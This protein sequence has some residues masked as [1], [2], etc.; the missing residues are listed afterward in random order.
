MFEKKI[1]FSFVSIMPFWALSQS[2]NSG[3]G[4]TVPQSKLEVK[5]N[6]TTSATSAFCVKNASTGSDS[7]MFII[8]NDGNVGIGTNAPTSRL[9]TVASGAKTVNFTGSYLSNTATSS[10]ASITKYGLDLQST[11]TW[12][13]TSALNIGLN[14]NATGGTTNYAALF[15]GG[16]VGVGTSTPSTALNVYGTLQTGPTSGGSSKVLL[17]NNAGY[18]LGMYTQWSSVGFTMGWE[19]GY[20]FYTR[21]ATGNQ[22][23]HITDFSGSVSKT[24]RNSTSSTYIEEYSSKNWILGF[25]GSGSGYVM[26]FEDGQSSHASKGS[27]GILF[28]RPGGASYWTRTYDPCLTIRNGAYMTEAAG[29][30][31]GNKAYWYRNG[32]IGIGTDNTDGAATTP[33]IGAITVNQGTK[34]GWLNSSQSTLATISTSGSSTFVSTNNSNGVPVQG[35]TVGTEVTANGITRTVTNVSISGFSVNSAVD[36]SA[37]YT[38]TY[39]NPYLSFRDG[40]APIMHVDP[41]G[42]VG[43]GTAT[44]TSI[45]HTIA[46]GAKTANYT[47]NYF[48]N[49]ATSS[50]ASI[51]KY[52]ADIQSTGTWNGTSAVNVGLNVNAT[53]GTTNYAALFSGGNVGVGTTMPKSTLHSSGSIGVKTTSKTATYTAA[54]ETVILCDATSASFTINL[55]AS[56]GVTDRVYIIKKTD[57]SGNTITVDGNAS[58]TIDGAA[59]KIISTQYD[60]VTVVCDGSNWHVID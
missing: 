32:F 43:I 6:G 53:G 57:S 7:L 15:N 35:V 20:S 26:S 55:P 40:T 10:T 5:G 17:G 54:D 16:N 33:L 1:I 14:V 38:M 31:F 48:S 49:T 37:G 24:I 23:S 41:N 59:T 28:A 4:S 11:G 50:T 51:N 56:T 36:W 2:T 9:H 45:L 22:G 21:F 58:E 30:L 27:S 19:S 13:G 12:N 39:K 18:Q 42:L 3:I 60:R 47:G 44:P 29:N 34:S 25:G 46:S 52:G 8:Q